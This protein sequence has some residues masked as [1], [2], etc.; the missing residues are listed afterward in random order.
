LSFAATGERIAERGERLGVAEED[1][2]G[3]D[4]RT[5]LLLVGL[6]TRARFML[7]NR[8]EIGPGLIEPKLALRS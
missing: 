4:E 1:R 5:E 7:L 3:L 8:S 6:E 2:V